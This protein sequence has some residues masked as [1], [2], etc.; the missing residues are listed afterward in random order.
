MFSDW[1]TGV[2]SVV[3]R[4][5]T[6]AF[7]EVCAGDAMSMPV[8]WFYT[9]DHIKTE[10]GDWIRDFTRPR[11][12]HPSSI[13]HLSNTGQS[14]LSLNQLFPVAAVFSYSQGQSFSCLSLRD[15][16]QCNR[17]NMTFFRLVFN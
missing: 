13:L 4:S 9:V 10:Y 16:V 15:H 8:H 12:T 7:W 3:Q 5:V 2:M 6:E 17:G 14:V 1:P 11:E